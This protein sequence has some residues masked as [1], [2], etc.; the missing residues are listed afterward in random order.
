MDCLN[1]PKGIAEKQQLLE[2]EESIFAAV[3]KFTNFVMLCKGTCNS[4][5]KD[6]NKEEVNE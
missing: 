1:C 2:K 5:N 6:K 4:K 3:D